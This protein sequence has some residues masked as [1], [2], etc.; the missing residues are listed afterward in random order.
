MQTERRKHI[1]T[2]SYLGGRVAF[3]H[4]YATR[5]CLIRN[6]SEDGCRLVFAETTSLPERFVLS[7]PSREQAINARLVWR[8]DKEAGV[9]FDIADATKTVSLDMARRLKKLEEEK[10]LLQIRIMELSGEL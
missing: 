1:R 9:A 5:D 7:I 3:N 4:L 10:R 6:I 2:T 8:S